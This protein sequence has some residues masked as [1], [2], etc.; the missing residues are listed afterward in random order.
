MFL[1]QMNFFYTSLCVFARNTLERK[2]MCFARGSAK[3][4]D[5]SGAEL[6]SPEVGILCT[7]ENLPGRGRTQPALEICLQTALRTRSLCVFG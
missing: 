7:E 2:K 6:N 3:V 5:Q 4:K 1:L